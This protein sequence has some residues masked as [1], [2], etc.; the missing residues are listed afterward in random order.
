MEQYIVS[1]RKY[2]PTT[3][4]SVVGQQALTTTLKNAISTGRLAHAYLFCG[5]RGVGKTSCARIFAK[6]INCTNRT[7]SG[8]ACNE[9]D[10][11]R[12]FNEGRSMN[13]VELDAA[14]NNGVE[15]MRDL[16]DQV[17]TPPAVGKYRVFIIDEVH[18]LSSAAFNAFLK[19]LEEPPAYVVFILATTEKHKIIPTILSRCQIYDFN[20]ISIADIVAHLQ[21]VAA[22]Q[23]ITA[24][25]DA[26]NVIARKADGGMRDALSIFD[27][28][29][30]SANGHIT[31]AATIANLN[32]LDEAYYNRLLDAFVAQNIADALLIYRDIRRQ[33]FDSQ[34]FINGLAD[35][36]RD[37]AVAQ[38]PSTLSLVEATDDVRQQLAE[39]AQKLHPTFL[40]RAMDLCNS[41]DF[42]F[43]Q[44]SNKQFLVELTLIKLCQLLSPS[45]ADGADGGQLQSIDG[46]A[47][48]TIAP[49]QVAP[50]T[51][52]SAPQ[53][54]TAVTPSVQSHSIP[55]PAETQ[56]TQR[57]KPSPVMSN[58]QGLSLGGMQATV[59]NKAAQASVTTGTVNAAPVAATPKEK[60]TAE[61]SEAD[62]IR[63]W[64]GVADLVRNE[65][66]LSSALG[67]M[68]PELDGNKVLLHFPGKVIYDLAQTHMP[69]I[70]QHLADSLNNDVFELVGDVNTSQLPH[71]LWPDEQVYAEMM[72]EFPNLQILMEE[73]GMRR[74]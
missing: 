16:V 13:I 42:N 11:C 61:F 52:P 29:A 31:Y 4:D 23:G 5:T 22:D 53:R 26:L 2:R 58:M 73:F 54:R 33:G 70:K 40:Y 39:R 17:M 64:G 49:Q 1:A 19:T 18:M 10:S 69:A 9:C 34:Q 37:L 30:A 48:S 72:K 59:L 45:L 43:R 68:T 25:A 21:R 14:S 15:A 24:D 74:L 50:A 55:Q 8:D 35:Y 7:A 28:I 46:S 71:E 3:F 66:A 67:L 65:K 6:T 56:N 51:S 57:R 63:A 60:R 41:A 32:V 62:L 27:Q 44:A 36:L 38:D 47:P 20:R 12:M